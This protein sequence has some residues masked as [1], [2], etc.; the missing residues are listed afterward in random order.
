LALRLDRYISNAKP[1]DWKPNFRG[2]MVGNGVTNWKYDCDPAYFHISYYHGLISDSVFD[3]FTANNCDF[4]YIDAPKPPVITQVCMEI[5]EKFV[6]QVSFINEYDIFGKCYK[7]SSESLRATK[8]T[9]IRGQYTSQNKFFKSIPPCLYNGLGS[10][11]DYFNNP[12]VREQLNIK[13]ESAAKW[14]L[15]SDTINYTSFQ[16]ASQWIYA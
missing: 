9:K 12:L 1:T 14:A 3:N 15:C 4:S 8:N 10:M 2:F 7:S 5:F 11:I 6:S 13:N 16:N